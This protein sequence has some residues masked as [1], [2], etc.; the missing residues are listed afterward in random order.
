MKNKGKSTNFAGKYYCYNLVY[1]EHFTNI[2]DA[3][4][5]EKQ[6]KGLKREKKVALINSVNPNWNFY[7]LDD[8]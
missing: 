4:A 2:K 5:R 6:L 8:L 7:R 3:I 1:F